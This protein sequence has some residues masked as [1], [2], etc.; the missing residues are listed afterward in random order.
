MPYRNNDELPLPMRHSLPPHA[1]DIDGKPSTMR[2][3]P[4]WAKPARRR[5]PTA[6]LGPQSSAAMS[7][8]W[9]DGSGA[10]AKRDTAMSRHAQICRHAVPIDRLTQ[11]AGA[12]QF[13]IRDPSHLPRLPVF[14]VGTNN[15]TGI[16]ALIADLALTT[17][18][19]SVGELGCNVR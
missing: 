4:M 1:Q 11:H 17:T 5:R 16:K 13:L 8:A 19:C 18:S 3:K 9:L 7:K 6:L 10:C 15:L 2:S 14:S 12:P